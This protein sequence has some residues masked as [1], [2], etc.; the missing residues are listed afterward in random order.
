[1]LSKTQLKNCGV[2]GVEYSRLM[3]L[4]T[5]GFDQDM[6]G[7]WR[8]IANKE[9]CKAAAGQLIKDYIAYHNIKP[10]SGSDILYWHVGQMQAY[11]G[12]T[13]DAL[14]YFN[15]SYNKQAEDLTNEKEW[16]L[17]AEGTIAF[18]KKEKG[19]LIAAKNELAKYKVSDDKIAAIKQMQKN[20]PN[21]MFPEG[22]PEKSLN[23]I[24]LEGLLRCFDQ[25]Y[26]K[27]YGN[28]EQ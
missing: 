5:H 6:Q 28:C 25:P 1:M 21:V 14:K 7:G 15:M 2:S 3:A 22:F 27:A 17:Y 12:Q 18:L 16:A 20:N 24:A 26:S 9:N 8:E 13:E 11:S 23:L 19:R 10:H 4:D